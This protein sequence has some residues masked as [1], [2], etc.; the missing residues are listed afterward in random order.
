MAHRCS[1]V[2]PNSHHCIKLHSDITEFAHGFGDVSQMN[3]G[4]SG[5]RDVLK[6]G[7]NS[8]QGLS[9]GAASH[10]RQAELQSETSAFLLKPW[11]SEESD[12]S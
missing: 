10:H 1:R 2:L 3:T 7:Y 8:M 4:L 6:C 9:G 12:N 11:R 5:F